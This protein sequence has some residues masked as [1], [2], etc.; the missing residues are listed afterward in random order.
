MIDYN[1]LRI[2]FNALSHDKQ[3]PWI[4]SHKDDITLHLDSD[5]TTFTFDSEESNPNC[6]DCTLFMLD[7]D[8]G[9]RDGIIE[10][11]NTVGLKSDFV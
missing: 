11:L 4:M 6:K 3:W 1:K 2:K 10:L 8:I 5:D 9:N 7:Y